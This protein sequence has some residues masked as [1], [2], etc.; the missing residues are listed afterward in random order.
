MDLNR[1][2]IE[3]KEFLLKNGSNIAVVGG[4]PSGSFFA[5]FA[6]TLAKKC[7]LNI[8]IDIFEA[9]DF[10]CLGPNGCNHCGGIVSESLIQM[11][12]A[13]GIILP[14]DVIRSSIE[15]YTLHLEQG[16]TVIQAP[17]DEQKIVS[18]FRGLGP[19]G[20]QIDH[21]KSFDQHLLEL[22]A[23]KGANIIYE[24]VIGLERKREGIVIK[25][26]DHFAKMYD[27]VIGAGGL[28]QNTFELFHELCPS[29]VVPK[30]TRTHIC[31]IHLGKK[32]IDEYLG[33]S[34]HVFLLNLPNIKFG[35]LIPKG[36]YVT[37]VLLGKNINR[38]IVDHFLNSEPVKKCFP[39]KTNQ[40]SVIT[41]SCY[42]Y[43]NIKGSKLAYSDRVVLIGDSS[44]SKLYKN[45]IG[46]AFI[47]A[48]AAANTVIFHGLSKI[49][50]RKYFEPI[51]KNL[52][53]DNKIGRFIFGVTS[54][55]QK[56]SV[57]KRAMLRMVVREQ[58]SKKNNR[59]ASSILWDT[60]TGGAPYKDILLRFLNPKIVISLLYN[61]LREISNKQQ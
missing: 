44:S 46:A 12:A 42:P 33:N 36:N 22:C 19:S 21:Q 13:E 20:C 28:N 3:E 45:G 4:G 35:A 24:R 32:L 50:F 17:Y 56:S 41:C 16:K 34:M 52:D 49:H 2:T 38:N 26:K 7:G 5:Y 59:D 60:F 18:V 23:A 48:K 14:T 53:R 55:I 30:T 61:I 15:S 6:L 37:M 39:E 8:S 31:E 51:C 43:I 9:K 25:T 58:E 47:T 11:L 40:N 29:F 10:N 1:Q 57:L 54:I 27:L